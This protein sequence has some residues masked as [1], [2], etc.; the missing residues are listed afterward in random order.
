MPSVLNGNIMYQDFEQCLVASILGDIS[1]KWQQ[2]S[3]TSVL[4]DN[5]SASVRW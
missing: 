2:F 3:L 1:V 4:N 5:V